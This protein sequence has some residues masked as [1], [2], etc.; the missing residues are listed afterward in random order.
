MKT[1]R[2]EYIVYF[3]SGPEKKA[4]N[5]KNCMCELHAKIKLGE[6][7]KRKYPDMIKLE[8]TKCEEDFLSIFNNFK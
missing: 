7:L 5:V 2:V 3:K 4:M 8:I 6:Y 1:Y